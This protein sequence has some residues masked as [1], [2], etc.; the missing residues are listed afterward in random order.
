MGR[1]PA[2]AVARGILGLRR[3]KIRIIALG[4]RMPRWVRE[5]TQEYSQRMPREMSVELIEL[6][7]EARNG[8]RATEQILEAESQRILSMLPDHGIALYALDERGT[9]W[10]TQDLATMIANVL[11]QGTDLYF[12]I[13][14]ADGLHPRIKQRAQA[15]LSLS[16]MTLP[17]GMARA[18]LVEQLYRAAMVLKGH[19]YHRE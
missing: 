6:K 3:L 4:H 1:L 14:S 19:P 5:V 2:S 17:H 12:I 10:S 9:L 18:I 11:P 16:R 13:G 7:P 8:G 15:L